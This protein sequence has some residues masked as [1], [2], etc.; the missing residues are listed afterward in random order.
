MARE[1]NLPV[2]TSILRGVPEDAILQYAS[3]SQADLITMGTRGEGGVNKHF[4][5]STAA[6]VVRRSGVPTLTMQ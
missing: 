2:S 6:R 1:R 3:G 5:G 4:L